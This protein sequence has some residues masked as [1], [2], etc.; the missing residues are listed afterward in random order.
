MLDL[1]FL[2]LVQAKCR[3]FME[4][5]E[6]LF[7]HGSGL[8]IALFAVVAWSLWQY[9]NRMRERQSVWPLHELGNRARALLVEFWEVHP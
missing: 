6:V 2:F 5:L 3:S 9:R 1:G 4:L 7:T 8:R